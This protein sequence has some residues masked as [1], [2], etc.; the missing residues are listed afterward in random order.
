MG[1]EN[2]KCIN[3]VLRDKE[4]IIGKPIF[5]DDAG[6]PLMYGFVR[7]IFDNSNRIVI[8]IINEKTLVGYVY[9]DAFDKYYIEKK[10]QKP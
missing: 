7:R 3:D 10:H 5:Y 8:E 1:L 9:E 6:K 2:F 4:N